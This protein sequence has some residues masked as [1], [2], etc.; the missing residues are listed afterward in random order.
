M[1]CEFCV[2]IMELIRFGLWDCVR[3]VREDIKRDGFMR[4]SRLKIVL[5]VRK[6]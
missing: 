2:V 1:L 6:K 3:I 5:Y 4:K